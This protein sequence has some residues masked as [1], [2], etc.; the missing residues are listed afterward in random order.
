MARYALR[1]FFDC[2]H[3]CLWSGNSAAL[4]KYGYPV[5]LRDLYLSEETIA[6]AGR[7]MKTACEMEQTTPDVYGVCY[8]FSSEEKSAHR[9]EVAE[10]LSTIRDELGAEFEVVD[11]L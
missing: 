6:K 5:S 1:F 10:L 4:E 2:G 8:E 3:D 7:L 9:K 11:E